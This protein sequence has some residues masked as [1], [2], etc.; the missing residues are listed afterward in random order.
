LKYKD[1]SVD[2]DYYNNYNLTE[3]L[4]KSANETGHYME[5]NHENLYKDVEYIEEKPEKKKKKKKTVKDEES[6]K[7][8]K[9][10][11][12]KVANF[13]PTDLLTFKIKPR[14]SEVQKGLK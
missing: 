1:G 8:R 4:E 6:E 12:E 11:E 3:D 2:L 9:E 10:W 13:L 5:D 7:E 14:Q